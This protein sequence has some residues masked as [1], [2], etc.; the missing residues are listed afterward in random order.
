MMKLYKRI[1]SWLKKTIIMKGKNM[2]YQFPKVEVAEIENSIGLKKKAIQD[3]KHDKPRSDSRMR[4]N[5][6]EEAVVKG[7][8]YRQNQVSKAAS[9]LSSVKK[10]IIDSTAQL[11]K[12][13]FFID[14][15]KSDCKQSITTAEANLSKLSA[16]FKSEDRELQ[17]YKREH[18]IGRNPKPLTTISLIISIGVIAFLFI[19][20]MRLNT[21]LLGLNTSTLTLIYINMI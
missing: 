2:A 6:E 14:D 16:S 8:E 21:K 12:K 18:S 10:T 3:G 5:C 15:I 13:H 17:N 9:Y 20:E 1:I 4:S 7:D 19:A 11:G